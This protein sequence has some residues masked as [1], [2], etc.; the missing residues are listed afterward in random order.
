MEYLYNQYDNLFKQLLTRAYSFR[1][2][3]CI[4]L[5]KEFIFN[6][7]YKTINEFDNYLFEAMRL[8][9]GD[10][11]V[12]NNIFVRLSDLDRRKIYK[13]EEYEREMILNDLK[14]STHINIS[15]FNEPDTSRRFIGINDSCLSFT[16]VS[17]DANFYRWVFVSRSTEVNKMLPADLYS[18][19]NIIKQWTTWF[20][21]YRWNHWNFGPS[22]N[23]H[24]GIKLMI[25]LN[26]P[27]AYIK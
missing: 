19:G 27:H 1:G 14:F 3:D 6:L 23:E 5:N 16:Q 24:R 4:S 21:E 25:V 13:I 22:P 12:A 10:Y 17:I 2:S 15:K 8:N 20:I 18:I 26:N 7:E 11:T 9:R